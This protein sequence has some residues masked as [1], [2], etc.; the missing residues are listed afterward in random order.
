VKTDIYPKNL[1]SRALR[2]YRKQGLVVAGE[3]TAAKLKNFF[4]RSNEAIWFARELVRS[5]LHSPA[6]HS[7]EE[8]PGSF[9][10]I[11]PEELARWLRDRDDLAWAADPRELEI[12]SS[13]KHPW[14]CWR[15]GS[16]IV[17]FCKTGGGQVFI[18]DFERVLVLPERLA[19]LSDVYVLPG[20]RRKGVGRRLLLASMSLLKE[21]SFSVLSCHIPARN[22]A[23][24][25][26]FSS[27]G[28]QPF[29]KIRFVRI[30]G[31]STFSTRPELMLAEMT[32]SET[33]A[34]TSEG[35]RSAP[36]S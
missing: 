21:R 32:A 15:D 29:G 36:V 18:V 3:K 26:L 16:D 35:P 11:L 14:T 33:T 19:F 22:R 17:A 23:S 4:F 8:T 13:L 5:P 6:T 24:V 25:K 12:A 20:A 27:L 2:V 10:P 9:S 1:A 34:F 7:G 31:A 30:M 28:F